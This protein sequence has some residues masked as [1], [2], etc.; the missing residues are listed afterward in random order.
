VR[1]MRI[2]RGKG[3]MTNGRT[4]RKLMRMKK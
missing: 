3:S 4:R 1:K 2:R